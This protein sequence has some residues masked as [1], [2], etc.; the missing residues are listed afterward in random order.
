MSRVPREVLGATPRDRARAA[1][2]SLGRAELTRWCADLLSGRA[3][4]GERA[5]PDPGWLA[6]RAVDGWGAPDHLDEATAYWP[7]V[8][9]ARTL[10]HVWDD[11]VV[12]DVV[13]ALTDPAWRVREMCAKVCARWEVA[14][15]ADAVV[16]LL[17]DEVPRVRV[18]A[19]RVL[20]AV[21]EGEHA[22]VIRS[23]L[24]DPEVCVVAMAER[25]SLGLAERLDRPV[26]DLP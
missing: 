20:G 15:A 11:A 17:G 18:A 8:W 13:A 24:A 14:P 4:Y 6:G 19:L 7:R 25:M 16:A 26:A 3:T 12:T 2:K 9:A 1:A 22:A 5:G 10:L 21:G 23:A